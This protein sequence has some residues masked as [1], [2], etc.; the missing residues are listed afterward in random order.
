MTGL[1][2]FERVEL[3]RLRMRCKGALAS[4]FEMNFDEGMEETL[5]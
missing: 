1:I 5:F 3:G 2:T 4:G